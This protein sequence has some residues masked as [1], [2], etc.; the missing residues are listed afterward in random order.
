VTSEQTIKDL[1][2]SLGADLCG[3]AP[4]SRFDEAPK[5][6]HPYDIFPETRSVIVLAQRFPEGPFHAVSAI[7]YTVASE[8]ILAE[9]TQMTVRFGGII[10]QRIA[11]RAVPA[12]SEPYEYWDT[13]RREGRGLLSL[14]HAGRLAGLG[15]ITKNG[16]LTNV[17]YGNRLCLGAVLL[18]IDLPGDDTADYSFDCEQCRACVAACPA[19]AMDGP[20]V[21]QGLCR[22]HSEGRTKKGYPLY[23]C[24][25]CRRVCP[26]G[27]GS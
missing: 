3:I 18:D 13:E 7:P 11:A 6:F 25:A 23:V 9:V 26:H 8:V 15:V 16:L 19:R 2:Y 5:G 4:V 27:A 12:P 17:D 21:N 22:G 14:K 20:T 24:H 10:E 1:A